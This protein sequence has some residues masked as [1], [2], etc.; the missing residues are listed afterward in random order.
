MLKGKFHIFIRKQKRDTVSGLIFVFDRY[1][2]G[3]LQVVGSF[4]YSFIILRI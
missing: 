1:H 4:Y 3:L 2:S